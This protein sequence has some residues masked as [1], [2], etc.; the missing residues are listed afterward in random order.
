MVAQ[1]FTT[2][3]GVF[4]VKKMLQNHGFS[5]NAQ[6][7]HSVAQGFHRPKVSYFL[8]FFFA[9]KT[10]DEVSITPGI[11]GQYWRHALWTKIPL[12]SPL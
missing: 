8:P 7:V 11:S 6:S 2:L 4:W 1:R 3:F 12:Y 9:K 10:K 5:D